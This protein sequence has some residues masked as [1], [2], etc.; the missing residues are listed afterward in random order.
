MQR[1][2]AWKEGTCTR[3]LSARE[4]TVEGEQAWKGGMDRQEQACKGMSVQGP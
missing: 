2:Q 4:A 1:E 3:G